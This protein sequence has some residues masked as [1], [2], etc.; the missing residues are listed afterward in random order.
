MEVEEEPKSKTIAGKGER[1]EQGK[2]EKQGVGDKGCRGVQGSDVL[3]SFTVT[4]PEN[5][6]I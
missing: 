4:T 2:A 5:S 1:S 3:L 6:T